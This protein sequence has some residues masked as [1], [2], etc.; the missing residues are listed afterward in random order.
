MTDDA[1]H[2]GLMAFLI[3]GVAQGLAVDGQTF[4]L[5]GVDFVPASQG[6]VQMRGG[7]ADQDIAEDV[8]LGTT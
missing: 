4:I 5:P 2:M 7:D 1:H 6:A 3:E 8:S